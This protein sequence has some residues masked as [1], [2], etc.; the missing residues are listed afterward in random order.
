[1]VFTCFICSL[2]TPFRLATKKIPFDLTT[3][4]D[5][6]VWVVCDTANFFRTTLMGLY[7]TKD[8]IATYQVRAFSTYFP[9]KL[10]LLVV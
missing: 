9:D 6:F 7:K 10:Y 1:M 3:V 4:P 5:P 8:G 2:R